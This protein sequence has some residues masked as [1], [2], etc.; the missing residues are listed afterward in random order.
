MAAIDR[1]KAK[2]TEGSVGRTLVFV[3]LPMMVGIVGMVAFNLV[4]TFF[5][6]RLGTL[7]L[8]AMGF[9]FPVVMV[10]GSIARGLGVGVSSV[11]SRAIGQGDHHAVAVLY[12]QGTL[13]QRFDIGHAH[14]PQPGRAFFIVDRFF[15]EHVLLKFPVH[16]IGRSITGYPFKMVAF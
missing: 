16:Q 5:V 6:G 3:T 9:T 8:A 12:E 4:D 11:V 13:L 10:V 15:G 7:E 2:L 14:T 1:R